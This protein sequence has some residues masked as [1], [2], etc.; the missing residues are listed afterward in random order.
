M[1]DL[2]YTSFLEHVRKKKIPPVVLIHGEED[3]LRDEC[4]DAIVDALLD[5]AARSFNLDILDGART[6]IRDV[7]SI[8]A[9]YPMGTERRVVVV[10]D[11]ENLLADRG[12]AERLD[13][14]L[15]HPSES[16]CLIL[17]AEKADG[18]QKFIKSLR[19]TNAAVLVPRLYENQIPEW[20][21]ARIRAY[22]R[23]MED[24]ACRLLQAYVGSSLRVV[25]QEIRKLLLFVGDRKEIVLEDVAA[26]A[27]A[28]R[29]YT[30]FDLQGAVGRR[31]LPEALRILARMLEMGEYPLLIVTMLARFFVSLWK[32][33]EL[34][35]ARA[36]EQQIAS[37]LR[38]KPFFVKQTIRFAAEFTPAEIERALAAL[39]EADLQLKS[40]AVDPRVGL[41]VLI[42]TITST[43]AAVPVPQH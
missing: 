9:S 12:A 20:I 26:V 11:A 42:Y 32:V 8:A 37:E 38:M 1:D 14:Y 23:T 7:L 18:R 30:I 39:Y 5:K 13:A 3:L 17:T 16:T 24:D 21:A 40:S 6:E 36:S 28:S 22:G 4:V 15:Q 19:E 27:G 2:P 31:N 43:G 41:D 10:R 34:K 25:D 35:R 33:H 29:G